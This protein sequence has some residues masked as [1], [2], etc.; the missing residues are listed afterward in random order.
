MNKVMVMS[1]EQHQ[2]I[3]AGF[4][5]IGPVFDVMPIDESAV[6]APREAAA[7]IPDAERAAHWRW[8][9][10]GTAP[11]GQWLSV[12]VLLDAHHRAIASDSPRCF[13]GNVGAIV[14]VGY[15]FAAEGRSHKFFR[16]MLM[17]RSHNMDNDLV[18]IRRGT[19]RFAVVHVGFGDF[20]QCIGAADGD[21]LGM[22][23]R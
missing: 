6:C 16:T 17:R 13:R 8:N 4:A 12:F 11:D 7:A 2:V 9:R 14:D 1:A 18:A 20:G 23:P 5:A 10:P 21:G 22:F 19:R 3:Q 15:S